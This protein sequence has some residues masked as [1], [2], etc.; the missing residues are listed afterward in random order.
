MKKITLSTL[1]EQ[2]VPPQE[3]LL[4]RYGRTETAKGPYFFDEGSARLLLE[5]Y[6]AK[7][8]HC[9]FDYRHRSLEGDSAEDGIAAG[10][11]DLEL[12][13]DGLWAVNIKWTP[14]AYEMISNKEY[15]YISPAIVTDDEFVV[16]LINVALTNS[17]ATFEI[18][19]LI[20]S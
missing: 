18:E 10:W 20:L 14:K 9:Y 15:L 13:Q 6:L 8:V 11:F 1:I 5:R 16:K 2:S 19:P 4:I 17:P 12:R 7:G 3:F